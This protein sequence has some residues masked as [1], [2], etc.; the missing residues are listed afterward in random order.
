MFG[1]VVFLILAILTAQTTYV[2]DTIRRY[3]S[4]ILQQKTTQFNFKEW[5]GDSCKCA[6]SSSWFYSCLHHWIRNRS[7]L[8]RICEILAKVIALSVDGVSLI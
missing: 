7:E 1:L 6:F 3:C 4:V 5:L 8:S 2:N